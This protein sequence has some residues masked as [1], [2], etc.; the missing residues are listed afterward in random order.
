[1]MSVVAFTPTSADS[2]LV[3]SSSSRSWSMLLRPSSRAPRPSP[4]LSRVR[5][6]PAFRRANRPPPLSFSCACAATA[7]TAGLSL[8]G[9]LPG[10]G[11]GSG[12][13]GLGGFLPNPNMGTAACIWTR[14]ATR[15]GPQPPR[16]GPWARSLSGPQRAQCP[17][18]AGRYYMNAKSRK[19]GN[20][21]RIIGG[22]WRSRV[23]DFPDLPEL[24]PTP[25]RVRETLFNW[26]QFDITGAR[27]L[28]LF[29]GS[30]VLGFE[31]LSRGAASVMAF[32]TDTSAV[33]AL[34]ENAS[35]L[36]ARGYQLT[37]G[38]ALEWLQHGTPQTFDIVFLDPPFG[39]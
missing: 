36:G 17:P 38:S 4:R 12:A 25:D 18:L 1:M 19:P 32:E 10:A 33:R 9:S 29:A 11:E 27:C 39:A 24:R 30:G 8:P 26:L 21:I 3:S 23:L 28:D 34:R 15:A 20:R 13:A 22:D 35:R 16:G 6:R 5:R 14:N 7:S 31:A 2:S 37:P